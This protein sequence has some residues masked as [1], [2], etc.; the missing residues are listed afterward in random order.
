MPLHCALGPRSARV[1]P[2]LLVG[3]DNVLEEHH[4]VLEGQHVGDLLEHRLQHAL[5]TR[6]G[7][8]R[9]GGGR[10]AG[11]RQPRRPPRRLL[12]LVHLHAVVVVVRGGLGRVVPRRVVRAEVHDG[13]PP[14]QQLR[15][16]DDPADV[17]VQDL[18][19]AV[20]VVQQADERREAGPQGLRRGAERGLL[21]HVRHEV[22]RQPVQE[23]REELDFLGPQGVGG[24]EELGVVH[25]L[26]LQGVD[27]AEDAQAHRLRRGQP[28]RAERLEDCLD[29]RAP[30]EAGQRGEE[31]PGEGRGERE[32]LEHLHRRL[33]VAGEVE[34]ARREQA[35]GA[36]SVHGLHQ[37]V[38]E[39]RGGEPLQLPREP[40]VRRLCRRAARAVLPDPA[41]PGQPQL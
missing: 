35:V 21:G 29:R 5:G 16:R 12:R 30:H 10:R 25:R 1:P 8:G 33:A 32:G 39:R 11:H 6:A 20:P 27:R 38:H 13:R 19:P 26:H 9:R 37:G 28:R 2:L 24:A 23:G 4:S 7:L 34:S 36:L 3:E 18:L 22:V 31:L 41:K 40:R 14:D 15:L 17:A